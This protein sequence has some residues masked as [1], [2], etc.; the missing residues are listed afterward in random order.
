MVMKLDEA[1]NIL[2]DY[3]R[4]RRGEESPQPDPKEVGEAID[5]VLASFSEC[6]CTTD[7]GR[8]RYARKCFDCGKIRE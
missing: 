5:M 7:N 3:N 6:T 4:W 2:R 8:Y 1:V